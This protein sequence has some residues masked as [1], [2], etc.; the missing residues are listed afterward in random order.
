MMA[1]GWMT[2]ELM[3]EPI[4]SPGTAIERARSGMAPFWNQPM[5]P[6]VMP[7]DCV[8]MDIFSA[9]SG[10]RWK[11][12]ITHGIKTSPPPIAE[13]LPSNAPPTPMAM[14]TQL[15]CSSSRGWGATLTNT[16][17]HAATKTASQGDQ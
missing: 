1:L 11:M 9:I 8:A 5:A 6:L 3:H 2:N 13:M 7:N 17:T 15:A 10:G 16:T 14:K 12:K 4:S